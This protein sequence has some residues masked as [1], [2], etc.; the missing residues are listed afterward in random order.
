MPNIINI[1]TDSK[2]VNDEI[3]SIK[4]VR[5]ITLTNTGWSENKKRVNVDGIKSTDTPLIALDLSAVTDLATKQ[6]QK[7]EWAKIVDAQTLDNWIEFYC[8]EVPTVELKLI[9][10]GV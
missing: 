2:T 3:A 8:S 1:G 9:V 4:Q 6:K 10:K 7:Q 5:K